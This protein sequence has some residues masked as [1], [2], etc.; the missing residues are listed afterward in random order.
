ME[1]STDTESEQE[2]SLCAETPS[3]AWEV[4]MTE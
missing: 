2:G 3:T 4:N 1:D